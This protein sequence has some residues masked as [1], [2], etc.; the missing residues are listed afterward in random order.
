MG[1]ALRREIK[2]CVTCRGR[3]EGSALILHILLQHVFTHLACCTALCNSK[4]GQLS[5]RSLMKRGE[6][7]GMYFLPCPS[8]DYCLLPCQVLRCVW[9]LDE[10]TCS[11][12][13]HHYRA[14]NTFLFTH[15]RLDSVTDRGI[16]NWVSWVWVSKPG[17]SELCG[18][19]SCNYH[20]VKI[21]QGRNK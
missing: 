6:C 13:Q 17:F 11:A 4:P 7:L 2:I 20:H 12:A 8:S 18:F 16:I 10:V 5:T 21:H 3:S 15:R 1:I 19:C 9:C 14:V